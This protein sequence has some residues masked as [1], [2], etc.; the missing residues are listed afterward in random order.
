MSTP[1]RWRKSSRSNPTNCVELACPRDA[2]ALRDSKNPA[3]TLHFPRPQL[4][5]FLATITT[6]QDPQDRT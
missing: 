2:F 4:A 1:L 3:P 6:D 5:G